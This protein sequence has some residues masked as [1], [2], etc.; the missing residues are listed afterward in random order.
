MRPSTSAL[1]ALV[2]TAL[3]AALPAPQSVQASTALQRC[4]TAEGGEIFTDKA[5]GALG[6]KAAPIP[7]AMMT[8]LARTMTSNDAS[9]E[10]ADAAAAI[11]TAPPP[12][13]RSP[14]S[15]CARTTRQL[16]ADL[17]GSLALGDVNRIA[18]SYHWAG[19]THADGQRI[20]S[21][22]ETLAGQPV[23]DVHYFDAQIVD[24]AYGSNLYAD[25]SGAGRPLTGRAGNLQ[26]QLGASSVSVVDLAVER[27]AGCYFVRF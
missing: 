8:R 17:R 23:R 26:L 9:G 27:Y 16:E 20:M 4:T 18:E 21:R 5:C 11:T 25:A 7:A 15:G 3:F 13:R 6:A 19:M 14:A 1:S 10:F 22:L 2:A 12:S 24:A